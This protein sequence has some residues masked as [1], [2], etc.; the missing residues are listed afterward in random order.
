MSQP[1]QGKF[2]VDNEF[3]KS[4]TYEIIN[5]YV[6]VL[7]L[8]PVLTKLPAKGLSAIVLLRISSGSAGLLR[9]GILGILGIHNNPVSPPLKKNLCKS[10][11]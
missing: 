10:G 11:I 4:H 8:V 3:Q 6:P 7:A 1:T 2:A 5:H 9:F